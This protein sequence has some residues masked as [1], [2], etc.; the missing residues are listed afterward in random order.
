MSKIY[1]FRNPIPVCTSL[2]EGMAIYCTEG[3]TF[4]NDVWCVAL[5][6]GRLR[7]FRVD[8]IRMEPNST[9]DIQK[10]APKL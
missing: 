5:N 1:E 3:G 9:F 7:H 6:D 4:C 8:Q 10:P 2:G